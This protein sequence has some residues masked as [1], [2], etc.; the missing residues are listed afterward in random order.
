MKILLSINGLVRNFK[1]SFKFI[2]NNIIKNNIDCS[3][4]IILNTSNYDNQ[5][6][7]KKNLNINNFNSNKEL[8]DY[9]YAILNKYNVIKILYYDILDVSIPGIFFD[10]IIDTYKN[11]DINNY[12]YIFFI[13]FDILIKNKINFNSFEKDTLYFFDGGTSGWYQHDVDFDYA[14]L[15]NSKILNKFLFYNL[16]YNY[17][18][19]SNNIVELIKENNNILD[20]LNIYMILPFNSRWKGYNQKCKEKT[21]EYIN[22]HNNSSLI[23]NGNIE[24]VIFAFYCKKVYDENY[25]IKIFKDIKLGLLR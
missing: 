16:K 9:I 20:I 12:D 21:I 3:F 25:E 24:L 7:K 10:R 22:H 11:A 15:G 4:D 19:Y 14:L 6:S 18:F 17:N 13:R 23:K 1:E 8:E 2:E 5:L